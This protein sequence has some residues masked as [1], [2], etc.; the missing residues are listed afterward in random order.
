ME[1]DFAEVRKSA[2]CEKCPARDMEIRF[3]Q[4]KLAHTEDKLQVSQIEAEKYKVGNTDLEKLEEIGGG[5]RSC[6]FRQERF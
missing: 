4:Y 1:R 2:A 5:L 6:D 3:L